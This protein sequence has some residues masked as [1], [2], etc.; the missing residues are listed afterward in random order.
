[1]LKINQ[2]RKCLDQ[3]IVNFTQK[4]DKKVL[5]LNKKTAVQAFNIHILS[6]LSHR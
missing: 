6:I 2:K 5:V 4:N 3:D 1:M